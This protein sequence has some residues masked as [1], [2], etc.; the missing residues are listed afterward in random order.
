MSA[1]RRSNPGSDG[2]AGA[3]A[4]TLRRTIVNIAARLTD[5]NGDPSYIYPAIDLDTDMACAVAQHHRVLTAIA[6]YRLTARRKDAKRNL[7]P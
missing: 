4:T 2:G 3:R 5:L 6:L 7:H 1:A